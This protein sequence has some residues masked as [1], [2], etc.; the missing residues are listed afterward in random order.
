MNKTATLMLLVLSAAQIA[1][2]TDVIN[3]DNKPYKLKVQSE[4]KLSISNY[5][6]KAKTS[7]YGL[8]GASF[9]SFE[10]PGSKI[11]AKKEER[12]TIRDGKL[13]K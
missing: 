8:C 7:M 5:V 6:I 12:L 1:G 3:Q 2:A 13:V 10:I 4:G 11:M 9:C